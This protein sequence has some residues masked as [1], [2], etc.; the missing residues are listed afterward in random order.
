M[1][2]E[3]N[4]PVNN[5]FAALEIESRSSSFI[6]HPNLKEIIS[7]SVTKDDRDSIGEPSI[8]NLKVREPA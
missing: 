5:S 2:N 6:H 1:N 3:K 7:I 4:R 8:V